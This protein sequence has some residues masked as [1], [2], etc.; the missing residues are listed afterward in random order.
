METENVLLWLYYVDVCANNQND[1]NATTILLLSTLLKLIKLDLSRNLGHS[2]TVRHFSGPLHLSCLVPTHW[3][4]SWHLQ[5]RVS[6]QTPKNTPSGRCRGNTSPPASV[7]YFA[8]LV[9]LDL[10]ERFI[11]GNVLFSTHANIVM[12]LLTDQIQRHSVY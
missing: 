1:R 9:S 7:Q 8:L 11:S 5:A 12:F 4:N 10:A 2:R 3:L 6:Y